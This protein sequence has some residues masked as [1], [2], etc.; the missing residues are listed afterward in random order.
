MGVG[1]MDP[2]LP[3]SV[4]GNVSV[5]GILSGELTL[6][7]TYFSYGTKPANLWLFHKCPY[8]Y[9]VEENYKSPKF[10]RENIVDITADSD[11]HRWGIHD[12]RYTKLPDVR[13]YRYQETHH[14]I[15]FD[16]I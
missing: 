12:V 14:H 2:C 4:R 13:M 15:M 11:G 7:N 5:G 9:T 1:G 8:L 10:H 6:K 3:S 16:K